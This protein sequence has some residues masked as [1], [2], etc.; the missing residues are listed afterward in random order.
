MIEIQEVFQ[1]TTE[2]FEKS[3]VA[4]LTNIMVVIDIR[5]KIW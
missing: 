3:W 2:E 4:I 5:P 1:M